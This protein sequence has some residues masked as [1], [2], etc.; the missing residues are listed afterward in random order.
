MC[1]CVSVCVCVCVCVWR[2][3]LSGFVCSV[4]NSHTHPFVCGTKRSLFSPDILVTQTV[5]TQLRRMEDQ[6]HTGTHSL[7]IEYKRNTLVIQ[8]Q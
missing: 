5:E 8:E 1:V 6:Q 4:P 2:V 7:W 3:Y